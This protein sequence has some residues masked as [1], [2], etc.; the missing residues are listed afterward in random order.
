MAMAMVVVETHMYVLEVEQEQEDG[1]M[2]VSLATVA[3][4][5]IVVED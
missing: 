5:P 1:L 2:K 4:W 3:E